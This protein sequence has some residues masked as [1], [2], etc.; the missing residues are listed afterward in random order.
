MSGS[1]RLIA[2]GSDLLGELKDGLVHYE[3][4]VS[5]RRIPGSSEIV[6]E[7]G[8]LRIGARVTLAQLEHAPRLTGPYRLL[9]EAARGVST[10]EIR[11]QGT[12]GGNLCQRPRCLHYR[13]PWVACAKKGGFGCP[14][15]ESRHQ[16]YLSVFGGGACV[17]V[18][19]SDLAPVLVALG[20][21][22]VIASME[23]ERV[24]PLS[25]FF[26]GPERDAKREN[27]LGIGEILAAI[28]LPVLPLDWRGVFLKSRER[29]AGDF[30]IVSAAVGCRIDDGRLRDVRL[31]L[32]GV[33][34]VP[35]PCP[36]AA[37]RLEG[38]PVSPEL[39]QAAAAAAFANAIPLASNGY[40]LDLGHALV[41]RAVI[42]LT[43]GV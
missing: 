5:L 33:A 36:E 29:T 18:N 17:A 7:D 40:K 9:A 35:R 38:Q 23:G 34:P 37:A 43:R 15:S 1:S 14:A 24:L 20:A 11:N 31:V 39:A 2:G 26:S 21:T 25:G 27:V 19:A 28:R 6:D 3:R 13:S 42:E 8:G 22:A 16:A 12:L 4:L 10:P 41:K 30:P 32:G